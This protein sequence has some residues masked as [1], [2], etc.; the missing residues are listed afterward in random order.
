[1]FLD[2]DNNEELK[3]EAN[4]ILIA[5]NR[6]ILKILLI[7]LENFKYNLALIKHAFM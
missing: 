5:I 6:H 1:M 4:N 7:T 2:G 3:L